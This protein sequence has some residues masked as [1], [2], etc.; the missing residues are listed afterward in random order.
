MFT[1]ALGVTQSWMS[2]LGQPSLETWLRVTATRTFI[3]LGRRKDRAREV[4]AGDSLSG[5]IEPSDLALDLFKVEYRAAVS[6]ALRAAAAKLAPSDRHLLRQ[7]LVGGLTI[8]QLAAVL[9]I[10]R[11][12]AAR[13][14]AR[15]RETLAAHVRESLVL[16]LGLD[17]H[18]LGEVYGLVVSKLDVSL[19][20]VLATHPTP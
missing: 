10:H 18:E 7:H 5:A 16:S 11:A 17:D 8:D 4:L 13:R 15:A 14:I 1:A 6:A 2:T 12:T 20:T 19:R 3:D 9:G